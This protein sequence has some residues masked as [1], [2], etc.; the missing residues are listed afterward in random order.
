[1]RRAADDPTFALPYWAYDDPKQGLLPEPFRPG[2]DQLET[3]VAARRNTLARTSRHAAFERGVHGLP[4]MSKDFA[5]ALALEHFVASDPLNPRGGVGGAR[6]ANAKEFVASGAL[7]ALHDRFHLSIGRDGDLASPTTA[8]RD[9][10]YWLHAANIDRMWVKWTARGGAAPIDDDVWMKTRF[11]FVDEDGVDR[12]MT[13]ADVLDTQMQ[14]NYRYDDDPRRE[15]R[16]E[17]KPR[18]GAPPPEPV[19][20]ARAAEVDLSAR[21]TAVVFAPV[22]LPRRPLQQGKRDKRAPA[23]APRTLVVLRDV[24]APD[25]APV[26]DLF[27]VLEGPNVFAPTTTTHHIGALELFGGTGRDGSPNRRETLAFDASEAFAKLA[28]GRGFNMRLLRLSIVRRPVVGG[29]GE[30]T[31]PPDPVPPEIGLIELVR[32]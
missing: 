28:K 18:V 19:V 16:L 6:V 2:S 30:K 29:A 7:E 32:A 24:V 13:G 5:A 14:L 21:E 20:L 11:T 15:H 8:A 1:V 12:V 26:Y 23:T 4:D 10:V 27:L 9:P 31:V 17:L 22:P 25:R 3:P